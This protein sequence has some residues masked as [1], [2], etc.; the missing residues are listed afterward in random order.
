MLGKE[1]AFVAQSDVSLTGDQEVCCHNLS[2]WFKK[3][4]C[5]FKGK[6]CAQVTLSKNSV[7]RVTDQ[8]NMTIIVGVDWT[9]N[10]CPAEPGY[11]STLLLQTV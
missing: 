11:T 9:I 10:P 5:Q 8:H 2:H 6:E 7:N 1:L 4:S 3:G